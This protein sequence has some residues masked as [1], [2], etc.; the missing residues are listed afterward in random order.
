MDFAREKSLVFLRAAAQALFDENQ[1]LKDENDRLR[2]RLGEQAQVAEE[3][4]VLR[5][6]LAKREHA[7]F[8]RSSE[9]RPTPASTEQPPRAPQRGHGPREQPDLE[10]ETVVHDV[11]ADELVCRECGAQMEPMGE[12]VEETELV[13]VTERSFVVER[14][15]CKKYRCRCNGRVVTAPGPLRLV[16]G[17]RYSPAFATEV[18][19]GKYAD[20]M[21]LERQVTTMKREGLRVDSQTL[22]DQL[23]AQA[24]LLKP[25]YDLIQQTIL[26][27]PVLGADETWWLLMDN[28]KTRENKT[29]QT[30]A[31][32]S[33][34]LV[35][36]RILDSRSKTAA[37]AL[38]GDYRG[39]VMADGYT[40]YRS[41]AE[42]KGFVVANCWAH[43]RRKFVEAQKNFPEECGVALDL[44]AKLYDV[45]RDART[46]KGDLAELRAAVSRPIVEGLFAW[47]RDLEQRTLPRSGLGEALRYMLN[48]ELG[49]TRYLRDPRIPIDNNASER[50]LRSV[51][52]GRK[53]H[54]GSRSRRGTEVA[55]LFYTL[56]ECAK[57]AEVSPKAYLLAATE[58]AL[59]KPGSTLLPAEFKKQLLEAS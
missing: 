46:G 23:D 44:I 31:L 2:A 15:R 8:G 34:D 11:P 57:L 37:S 47:A 17:G 39:V 55:A 25:T 3:H 29:Y 52:L 40:V 19:V 16:K 30:W 9:R 53:N 10:V 24:T 45:E 14:H 42:E 32:V 33:P 41:L 49:L 58:L 13:T 27:A 38:L 35:A 1:R 48:L 5:E 51:V 6:L 28:G 59:R 26:T 36:Y 56:M 21:P 7:L 54:Y 43:A 50:T 4:A 12:V 20:H 22:W 18:A